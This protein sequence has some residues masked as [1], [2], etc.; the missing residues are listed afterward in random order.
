MVFLIVNNLGSFTSFIFRLV[1]AAPN[2]RQKIGLIFIGSLYNH[3]NFLFQLQ[4]FLSVPINSR[5]NCII[6][7]HNSQSIRRLQ[8]AVAGL[9]LFIQVIGGHNI[10]FF[11][12]ITVFSFRIISLLFQVTTKSSFMV[13]SFGSYIA[14]LLVKKFQRCYSCH[15]E[16]PLILYDP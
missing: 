9:A 12:C 15:D 8:L 7:S 4:H 11:F 16:S 10:P 6:C 2:L 3:T 13:Y 14:G 5:Q 1:I